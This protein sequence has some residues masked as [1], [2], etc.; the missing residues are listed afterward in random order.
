[1]HAPRHVCIRPVT[2]SNALC[3]LCLNGMIPSFEKK[4]ISQGFWCR[5]ALPTKYS[6]SNPPKR[7][8]RRLRD[9]GGFNCRPGCLLVAR[10]LAT[11]SCFCRLFSKETLKFKEPTYR[12]HLISKVSFTFDQRSIDYCPLSQG[13]M[14]VYSI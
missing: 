5:T 1:M 2:I 9:P 7:Q 12:G 10:A 14:F 3:H 4:M 11:D 8:A 13:G 6:F